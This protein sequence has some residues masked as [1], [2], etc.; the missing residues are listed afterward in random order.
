MPK[1]WHFN[2][3]HQRIDEAMATQRAAPAI[4]TEWRGLGGAQ[5]PRRGEAHVHVGSVHA[6]D[7]ELALLYAREQYVRRG[8]AVN[9][10][11]APADQILASPYDSPDFFAR[12]S[13][14]SYRENI[15]FRGHRQG[16]VPARPAPIRGPTAAD[17]AG[18]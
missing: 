4:D 3:Y 14:K 2:P 11:V 15:G 18:D 5:Q 6:P 9:L 10:W 12:T 13:D 17:D 8:T 1:E 7:A 16:R